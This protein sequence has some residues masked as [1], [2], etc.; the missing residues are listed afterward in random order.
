M[1]CYIKEDRDKGL[2]R[3]FN[4]Y[5]GHINM[6]ANSNAVDFKPERWHSMTVDVRIGTT[7]AG[8]FVMLRATL[9]NSREP[10]LGIHNKP[11]K[12]IYMTGSNQKTIAF[13]P[14]NH[15]PVKV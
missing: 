15:T 4:L 8:N 12:D 5:S 6:E 9:T 14:N 3:L 10:E 2:Q 13:P 11:V 1:I 7:W